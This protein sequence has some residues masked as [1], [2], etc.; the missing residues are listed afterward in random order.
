MKDPKIY[1]DVDG[2]LNPWRASLNHVREWND[3]VQQEL[4]GYPVWTSKQLGAYL[5]GLGVEIVW[6]TTWVVDD[7]ANTHI[8]E[9][10]GFSTTMDC[11]VYD[12]WALGEDL[13]EL[14]IPESE[15]G[16][17][18]GVVNHAGDHPVIW[19]DDCLGP[20]D[21]QMMKDR[22]DGIPYLLIRPNPNTGITRDDIAQMKMFID[23]CRN[24]K[25]EWVGSNGR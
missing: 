13:D 8:S 16:K 1:L 2:C 21:E 12:P 15:C 4:N 23:A 19:I 11:I 14:Y 10:H 20:N 3:Y 18:P 6:A 22:G 5:L 9:P 24:D 25:I 17:G 7:L